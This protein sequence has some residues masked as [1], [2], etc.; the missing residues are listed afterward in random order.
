MSH[1]TTSIVGEGGEGGSVTGVETTTALS[2]NVRF[3][4]FSLFENEFFYCVTV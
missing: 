4:C 1:P 3:R 2:T